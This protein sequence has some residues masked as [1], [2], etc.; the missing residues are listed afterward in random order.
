MFERELLVGDNIGRG[1]DGGEPGCPVTPSDV[2]KGKGAIVTSSS[3]VRGAEV[4]EPLEDTEERVGLE[5]RTDDAPI[6]E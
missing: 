6:V 4:G 3:S 2:K 5:T 1:E